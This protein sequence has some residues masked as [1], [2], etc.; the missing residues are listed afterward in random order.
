MS[1]KEIY[2]DVI[3]EPGVR[4]SMVG[5]H[6]TGIILAMCGNLLVVTFIISKKMFKKH[7]TMYLILNLCVCDLISTLI[8]EPIRLVDIFLP[9]ENS[10]RGTFVTQT[11]CEITGF[12]LCFIAGVGFHTNVAISQERLLVIC[13]P[14][15]AKAI[16]TAEI[17]R[18]MIA[19]IWIVSFFIT[20]PVPLLFSFVQT[21]SLNHTNI[22]MCFYIISDEEQQSAKIY[23]V[24]I[25]VIY[26]A[27][28][29]VIIIISYTKIFHVL[30][31][32]TDFGPGESR[33]NIANTEKYIRPRKSL[34]K[35]MV[36]VAVVFT[37]CHGPQFFT[38]LYVCLGGKVTSH[39]IFLLVLLDLFPLCSSVLNPFIY[40]LYSRTFQNGLKSLINRRFKKKELH[41]GSSFKSEENLKLN[42]CN[43][44]AQ[45]C[46]AS[47]SNMRIK[48]HT[49]EQNGLTLLKHSSKAHGSHVSVSIS[50]PTPKSTPEYQCPKPLLKQD[51]CMTFDLEIY[52][53]NDHEVN[54][55]HTLNN[56]VEDESWN[57][58]NTN[59]NQS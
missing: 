22:S 55:D 17:T 9:F 35:M 54:A 33:K 37:V 32:T 16:Y 1:S 58:A 25:F 8:Y 53:N 43:A 59:T 31:K 11:Y 28:P 52:P 47:S 4:Y 57:K 10:A 30:N 44:H 12:F 6:I 29:V 42:D 15:K 3:E 27:V 38:F 34:A 39:G 7:I 46:R 49:K 50:T 23:Y 14:L 2:R 5:L 41:S 36:C 24:A 19:V 26:Y 13:Y 56:D 40:A 21:V 51:T 48:K 45:S 18:K 20:L